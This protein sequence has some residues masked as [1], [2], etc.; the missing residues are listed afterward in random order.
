MIEINTKKIR[1]S[2]CFFLFCHC[3]R[4]HVLVPPR[5]PE[6]KINTEQQ[7]NSF[8]IDQNFR[9]TCIARDGRPPARLQWFIDNEPITEGVS[10]PR[11]VDQITGTNTTIHT[12]AQ[13][14]DRRLKASD[15]RRFLICRS[16]HPAQQPQEDRFQLSVR[17]KYSSRAISF[18]ARFWFQLE[19]EKNLDCCDSLTISPF[20]SQSLQSDRS[21]NKNSAST[22][23]HSAKP[24]T[25]TWP[26]KQIH[27]HA[28][29]GPSTAWSFRKAPKTYASKLIHRSTWATAHSMWRSASAAWPL[30]TPRRPTSWKRP[31]SLAS[32][33]TS[34]T[35]AHRRN[36]TRP[37]S[38]SVRSLASSSALP[39]WCSSLRALCLHGPPENGVLPVS[40]D[41]FV[42]AT[43]SY[44]IFPFANDN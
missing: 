2:V 12:V 31:T 36:C 43:L 20:I 35:S 9:A 41:F 4:V 34:S 21:H 29:N 16:Y 8:E 18:L 15:D 25:W 24:F 37:A 32:R 38:I 13:S 11:I 19:K 6:I 1:S 22:A 30:T 27:C 10:A 33:T 44:R 3:A 42:P 26:S 23:C 7:R 40:F 5:K 28:P 14:L 39:F 17:C